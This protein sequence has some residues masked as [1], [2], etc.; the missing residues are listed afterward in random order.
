MW[1]RVLR[2]LLFV[3]F[4]KEEEDSLNDDEE[5]RLP[6][7]QQP[8]GYIDR[9]NLVQASMDTAISSDNI[10]YKL[11]QKMGWKGQGLGRDGSGT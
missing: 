3:L 7:N 9:E 2:S 1:R 10:G 11:L 5:W 8:S 4:Q 6:I